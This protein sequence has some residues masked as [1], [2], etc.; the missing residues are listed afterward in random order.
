MVLQPLAS[1]SLATV[2]ARDQ[3]AIGCSSHR[4]LGQIARIAAG[5]DAIVSGL[6]R[7]ELDAPDRDLPMLANNLLR[8]TLGAVAQ[9]RLRQSSGT[10]FDRARLSHMGSPK[11]K[12]RRSG[13]GQSADFCFLKNSDLES[14]VDA[15]PAPGHY[16]GLFPGEKHPPPLAA[17]ARRLSPKVLEPIRRKLGVA[18]RVLNVLVTEISLQR[19]RVVPRIGQCLAAAVPQHVRVN[20]EGHLGPFPDPAAAGKR[21]QTA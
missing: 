13:P 11:K 9:Q 14:R 10:R 12:T 5:D 2:R 20:R 16:G 6:E 18:H 15:M 4:R 8:T 1:V 3:P 7:V 17:A 21:G 19:P